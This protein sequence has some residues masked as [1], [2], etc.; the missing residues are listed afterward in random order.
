M[1]GA[2]DATETSEVCECVR[3]GEGVTPLR[4]AEGRLSS[5]GSGTEGGQSHPFCQECGGI[6]KSSRDRWDWGQT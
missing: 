5:P 1:L 3:W 4:G 2:R 6:R